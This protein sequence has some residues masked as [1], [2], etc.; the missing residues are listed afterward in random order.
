MHALIHFAVRTLLSLGLLTLVCWPGDRGSSPKALKKPAEATWSF[1]GPAGVTGAADL[2]LRRYGG[3]APVDFQRVECLAGGSSAL[4]RAGALELR[5]PASRFCW[6]Q[7][8]ALKVINARLPWVWRLHP[9]LQC[10]RSIVR[11]RQGII[12]FRS[13]YPRV[14]TFYTEL[15]I[16]RQW[17]HP[18][19]APRIVGGLP[20]LS[21][22]SPGQGELVGAKALGSCQALIG[23]SESFV[24][25]R[26]CE[27]PGVV[28]TRVRGI[29]QDTD[30]DGGW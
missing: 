25:L 20:R 28:R 30:T 9:G 24:T 26:V 18:V 8:A 22:G 23:S 14:W 19:L 6:R 2:L 15:T 13:L 29:H 17:P 4:K 16:N 1:C 3:L 10:A 27:K 11:L 21:I 12:R 5:L 7:G